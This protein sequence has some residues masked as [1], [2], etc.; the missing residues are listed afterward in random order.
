MMHYVNHHAQF[1]FHNLQG[2]VLSLPIE[3][4]ENEQSKILVVSN[5]GNQKWSHCSNWMQKSQKQRMAAA[6]NAWKNLR[7]VIHHDHSPYPDIPKLGLS[8]SHKSHK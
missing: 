8:T 7:A 1:F 2:F 5:C 4:N 6:V 3:F